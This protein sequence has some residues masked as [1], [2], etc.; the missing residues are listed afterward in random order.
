[1]EA[2]EEAGENWTPL[3]GVLDDFALRSSLAAGSEEFR[4]DKATAFHNSCRE[5]EG[6]EQ[7]VP[8]C[9][10][11]PSF[12]ERNYTQASNGVSTGYRGFFLTLQRFNQWGAAT[13]KQA[14]L[15][16]FAVCGVERKSAEQGSDG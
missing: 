3:V 8:R 12:R 1:M 10:S 13:V 7:R 5:H 16:A 4:V 14:D 6:I 2:A 11:A 9:R 15:P